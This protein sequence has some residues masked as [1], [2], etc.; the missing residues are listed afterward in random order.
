MCTNKRLIENVYTHK[1]LF[2]NCGKCPACQQEKA[3]HR[4][5]RIKS[6]MSDGLDSCMISLTYARGCSPYVD[7]AEA[8]K[9][10]HGELSQ[11]NVYRD[12]GFRRV[13][14]TSDYQIGYKK[15]IGKRVLTTIDFVDKVSFANNKD[16]AYEPNKISVSYYPDVQR[17]VARLRI[18]LKRLYNY[19]KPIKTY[20]CS[21]YGA[22]SNRTHFH[23]LCFFRKGDYETLRS[24]IIKSWPFSDLQKWDRAVEKCYRGASYVA[25]YVN[26]GSDFSSFLKK[27]FKPKHSYSKGFGMGNYQYSLFKILQNFDRGSLSYRVL[28][29]KYGLPTV[30]DV[31]IP[32]YVIHRY[33]PKFKGYNRI[34]PVTLE[35]VMHGVSNFC[36][37]QTHELLARQALYWSM[38]DF[39]KISVRLNNAFARFKEQV[40]PDKYDNFDFKDY[41]S[42]H[43]RIWSCWS[44]TVLRLHLTNEDIPLNEK[45]DNLAYVKYKYDNNI[46]PRPV[47]FDGVDLSVTHPNE[48]SSTIRL[49]RQFAESF[50]VNIKHRKVS[51]A[52][53]SFENCEW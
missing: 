15:Y 29:D 20:I 44:A 11:L 41:V 49:T 48:F 34:S 31:P 35:S 51:N 30:L 27:Y 38:E 19:D 40:V 28:K 25:S 12:C 45:Y 21:E 23:L 10:A 39:N 18:N 33:F 14:C 37:D 8:Y 7:R 1:E 32:A 5:A 36:Y 6:T 50:H 46:Y 43:H 52:I 17:F 2:V 22:K 47:G 4:V 42:L 9:F 16:M 24:A 53:A 3:A 13:R 26:S